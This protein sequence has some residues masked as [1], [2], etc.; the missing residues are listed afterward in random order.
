MIKKILLLK[1]LSDNFV[2]QLF[3]IAWEENEMALE[4]NKRKIKVA[5]ENYPA[6][7]TGFCVSVQR[8]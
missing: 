1:Q 4:I 5:Y 6:S 8:N 3:A 7:G 2:V